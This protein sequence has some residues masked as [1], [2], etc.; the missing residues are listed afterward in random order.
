MTPSER[1]KRQRDAGRRFDKKRPPE[2][3][4]R[5]N[6]QQHLRIRYGLKVEQ[7]DAMLAAQG[8]VCAVCRLSPKTGRRLSVDHNH[9]T[10]SIRGLL[11]RGC[12]IRVGAVESELYAATVAYVQEW[13]GR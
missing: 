3:V 7:Y 13:S 2:T 10:G 1:K 8:G 6:H 9:R 12:N 4:A 11:C 5:R